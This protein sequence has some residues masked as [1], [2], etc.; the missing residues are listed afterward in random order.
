MAKV[1]EHLE[2]TATE[3]KAA[4]RAAAKDKGIGEK[5]LAFQLGVHRMNVSHWGNHE[6]TDRHVPAYLIPEISR[7]TEDFRLLDLLEETARRRA[8]ILASNELGQVGMQSAKVAQALVRG[9]RDAL[10]TLTNTLEHDLV[11]DHE[12]SDTIRELNDVIYEC[13]RLEHWLKSRLGAHRLNLTEP[14]R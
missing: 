10:R 12:Y 4:F 14:R 11:E 6:K 2:K 1:P 8:M 7:V 3:V 9:V 5:E 13:A